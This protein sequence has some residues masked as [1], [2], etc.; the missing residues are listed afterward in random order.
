[1]DYFLGI[2]VGSSKTHALI[3]DA[4][5]KCI[6]FGKAGGGNHQSAGYAGTERAL[7]QSFEEARKMS[8]VEYAQI[9]GAG[10]GVAGFDFPSD[11]EAHLQALSTLGLD[12]PMEIVNDGLNGLL[13]GA[14]RGIG[15]NVTAGSSNNARGRNGRGKEG[16]IVGNGAA[17]G[18]FGGGLEITWRALQAV[19]Y[20]WI[21]RGPATQLTEIFLKATGAKNV[22]ELMEGVS[23][24][25]YHLFAHLAIPVIAAAKAGDSTATEII[26]W[27]GEEL[28]WLAVAVA[29]QIEMENEAVEIIQAGSIYEAGEIITAPMQALTLEHCPKAKLIRLDGPPVVGAVILGMEQV[30]FDGYAVRDKIV[31]T[32]KALLN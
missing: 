15:V 13:A 7:R 22:M 26:R 27:A 18:E 8:G 16:R 25:K 23:S 30:N 29:R 5:G 10:F 28:G 1:M 2:D 9:V 21:K 3:V 31:A 14:T 17:F 12:C 11:R 24:Q 32:A 19:N 20:A 6:G 4:N